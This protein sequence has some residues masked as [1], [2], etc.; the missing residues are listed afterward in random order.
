MVR[1]H[2]ALVLLLSLATPALADWTVAMTSPRCSEEA[3]Q[4]VGGIARE[5]IE[6]A[7][8]RAEAS[9]APPA[10]VGR[11]AC[12]ETL[13]RLPLGSFAPSDAWT[14]LFG[15]TLD[16]LHDASGTLVRRFCAIAEREWHKTTSPLTGFVSGTGD[17]LPRLL[18]Q[19]VS[20]PV[21]ERVRRD[22]VAGMGQ[23][24][25]PGPGSEGSHDAEKRGIQAIWHALTGE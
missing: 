7:V 20:R 4:R 21:T 10:P 15:D 16:P 18:G 17:T 13:M 2:W 8:Q 14:V 23:R 11:L 12:L 5:Q 3:R 6:Y 9:I 1:C 22:P 24:G 25:E 19:V